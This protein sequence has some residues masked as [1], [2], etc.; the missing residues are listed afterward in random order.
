MTQLLRI[1]SQKVVRT[2]ATCW[3]LVLL[4]A[5]F[6]FSGASVWM[7]IFV[8]P[9]ISVNV[10]FFYHTEKSTVLDEKVIG[11]LCCFRY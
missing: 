5:D 1:F 7:D 8:T 11:C 10:T 6:P 2:A 9:N 4:I 3:M